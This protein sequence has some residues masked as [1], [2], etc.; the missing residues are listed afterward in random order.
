MPARDSDR[1]DRGIEPPSE[2][3]GAIY[4]PESTRGEEAERI[5]LGP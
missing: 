3:R 2:D 4:L 1:K 5:G